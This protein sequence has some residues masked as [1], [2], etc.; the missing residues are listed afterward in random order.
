MQDTDTTDQAQEQAQAQAQAPPPCTPQDQHELILESYQGEHQLPIINA[1][2]EKQL[3]EPYIIYTYRYFVNQWPDL[4]FIVRYQQTSFTTAQPLDLHRVLTAS[5]HHDQRRMPSMHKAL[6]QSASLSASST[7]ISRD[8]AS[9]VDT[10][11]CLVSVT[12]GGAEA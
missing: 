9:C 10:L 4:S 2:I 8:H 12:N 11:P 6:T 3:S 1:L 7:V 5:P